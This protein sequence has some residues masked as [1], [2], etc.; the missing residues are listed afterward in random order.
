MGLCTPGAGTR[1]GEADPKRGRAAHQPPRCVVGQVPTNAALGGSWTA[2]GRLLRFL[3]GSWRLFGAIGRLLGALGRLLEGSSLSL[4]AVSD[5]CWLRFWGLGILQY[6]G[7]SLIFC[8]SCVALRRLF[9][10]S[11]LFFPRALL[12]GV[13]LAVVVAQIVTKTARR[14]YYNIFSER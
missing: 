13:A 9:C 1:P 2:L 14:F 7:I 4:Q 11:H 6:N 3:G 12:G 5:G 8:I 10:S